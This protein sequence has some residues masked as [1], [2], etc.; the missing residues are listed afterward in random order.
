MTET[1]TTSLNPH[2][3][4]STDISTNIPLR[5]VGAAY[6]DR[7]IQAL[8]KS[9]RRHDTATDYA[10]DELYN[11]NSEGNIRKLWVPIPWYS[12]EIGRFLLWEITIIIYG[13]KLDSGIKDALRKE[14]AILRFPD[15]R[16][17][18][19]STT[20][21]FCKSTGETRASFGAKQC[22]LIPQGVKAGY[23]FYKLLANGIETFVERITEKL[24]RIFS[25]T[26]RIIELDRDFIAELR[27]LQAEELAKVNDKLGRLT[28]MKIDNIIPRSLILETR[29]RSFNPSRKAYDKRL[30]RI[31]EKHLAKAIETSEKAS[32]SAILAV[33]GGS[34]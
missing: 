6:A 12:A 21:I 14:A 11:S 25:T 7:A 20:F 17:L 1:L 13:G 31:E 10:P 26:Q 3:Y 8:L 34:G 16:H 33:H 4:T 5:G 2:G 24:P 22:Y 29:R 32:E 18:H 9:L 23:I 19:A 30:Q 27:A 28:P 15:H